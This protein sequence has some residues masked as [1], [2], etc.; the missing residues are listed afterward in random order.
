MKLGCMFDIIIYKDLSVQMTESEVYRMDGFLNALVSAQRSDK[1]P[2]EQDLFGALV[3]EWDF[4]WVDGHGS[5]RERHV[6]GEWIFSWILDGTAIQDL[7]ICP[8]RDER[9]INP[10]LDAEYG[11]TIRIY[12]PAT[13][14]W[15]IFYG[16]RGKATRLEAKKE[17]DKIVLT[18]ISEGKMK[19]VFSHITESTFLWQRIELQSNNQWT[20]MG[21]A[22]AQRK[23]RSGKEDME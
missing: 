9:K 11:T 17:G 15:D 10:Q 3:G 1:I 13:Q 7:F 2:A 20:I 4:E 19:W 6:K 14:A 12:N 23:N 18:E 16:C 5:P 21:E 8:S 22:I